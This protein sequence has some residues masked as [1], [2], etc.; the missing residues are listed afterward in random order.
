MKELCRGPLFCCPDCGNKHYDIETLCGKIGPT[1][2]CSNILCDFECVELDLWKHMSFTVVSAF[3]TPGEYDTFKAWNA[4][5]VTV[6]V[7]DGTTLR[8]DKDAL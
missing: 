4:T 8:K 6:E 7:L 2:R 5:K 1:C 3:E